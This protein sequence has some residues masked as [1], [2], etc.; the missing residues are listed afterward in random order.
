[1]KN[2]G[3]HDPSM[4]F[5]ASGPVSG[6]SV[7]CQGLSVVCQWPVRSILLTVAWFSRSFVVGTACLR[8]FRG[9]WALSVTAKFSNRYIYIYTSV[10]LCISMHSM[11]VEQEHREKEFGGSESLAFERYI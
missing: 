4:V 6:L 1:M 2:H 7:A 10:N 11:A 8:K 5:M 3:F 9:P